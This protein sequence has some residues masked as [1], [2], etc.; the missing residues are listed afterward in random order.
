MPATEQTW[1]NQ[2]KLHVWFAVSSLILLIAT[3]WMFVKDHAREWKSYQRTAR[4]V[5]NQL[6]K[7]RIFQADADVNADVEREIAKQLQ[8][9]QQE[10]PDP[11]LLQKFQQNVQQETGRSQQVEGVDLDAGSLTRLQQAMDAIR[12]EANAANRTKLLNEMDQFVD[13]ARRLEN[14]KIRKRKFQ[15]ADVDEAKANY[16]IAV[17][18][19]LPTEEQQARLDVSLAKQKEL[20]ALT[21]DFQQAEA[22]RKA[23]QEIVTQIKAKTVGL[24]KRQAEMHADG[25][26]LRKTLEDKTSSYF[27][28]RLPFINQRFLELPIL[29]AFG[30]PLKIDNLWT[31]GLK[32]PYGS[33]GEVRRFDRCTTCHQSIDKT[34]AGM[35]SSGAFIGESTIV[36]RMTV[37][38]AAESS[39]STAAT[40]SSPSDATSSGT[41]AATE[42]G[43]EPL[44]T[45]DS[46]PVD[47][48][49]RR[50][51]ILLAKQGL[52]DANAATIQYVRADSP[53]ALAKVVSHKA[54]SPGDLLSGLRTGDVISAIGEDKITSPDQVRLH[55]GERAKPGQVLDITVK[56]GLPHPYASHPRLDLFVGSLSPHAKA[57]IGCTVCHEGQGTA[58]E[59]KWASHTPN[60]PDQSH[61]WSQEHGWFNNHHWLF[62]MY[63]KRFA[64]SGC[65]K[66]HHDV[67]ELRPSER[68]PEDPAPKVVEGHDLITEY[69]CFGCHEINGYK[70]DRRIG[71]DMRVEPNYFA[72]AAQITQDPNFNNVDQQIRDWA[73]RVSHHPEDDH[74]RHGLLQYLKDDAKSSE[75]VLTAD[76]HQI[77]SVLDDVD[78]PGTLRKVGPSLRHVGNKVGATFLF[79]WI[80]DPKHFRPTTRMPKFFGHWDHL[81]DAE[82]AVAQRYEP[83][84]I[85]GSVQ[86]LLGKSQ[87][88]DAPEDPSQAVW[89]SDAATRGARSF[90]LRGCL[91]CHTH[92]NFPGHDS[93]KG[94]ELTNIGNKFE[95]S[96]TPNARAW[97]YNWLKNPSN[98]HARTSMPDLQLDPIKDASGKMVDPAA[99]IA[100]FLLKSK[101]DWQPHPETVD[102]LKIDS[103]SRQALRDL[104]REYLHKA[105]YRLEV[106]EFLGSDTQPGKGIPADRARG[107]ERELVVA[108]GTQLSDQQMLRY[109][110]Q[111]TISK[112]GCYACHDIPGFE[113]AK[114]IGA[115]L[116]DWGQKDTS[117]IAFEHISEYV[118]HG[119]AHVAPGASDGSAS[120]HAENAANAAGVGQTAHDTF[121]EAFYQEKL[122]EH[123][124][125]GF[126]WQKLKEPRS[127]DYKM[128]AIKDYNDRLRM[129]L[130]PFTPEQREAVVTFVLGLVAQP[131]ADQF[132]Y[133]ADPRQEA[134][135][136]GQKVIEK[137]NC[138]GCHVLKAERWDLEFA[139]D[140][141][142]P[143]PVEPSYPFVNTAFTST[144]VAASSQ[145][146]PLRSTLSTTLHGMPDR[147]AATGL[148]VVWD[149][150]EE[151]LAPEDVESY[152]PEKLIHRFQLW[153][154]TLIDSNV[155]EVTPTAMSVPASAIK[156]RF[157]AWGGDLTLKL[158]PT[159]TRYEQEVN[160]AAK[161]TEAWAWLPPP[162]I[163]EGTKVQAE[164][165][166]DFLLDPHMIR[167]A[168]VMRMPKF[169]M[170]SSE[171]TAL[172]NFFAA[173]DQA[174]YPYA[175]QERTRAGHLL[176]TEQ[177]Y[178]ESLAKVPQGQRPDGASRLDHAMNI[179]VSNNYCIKCHRVGDYSPQASDRAKAPD[180]SVVYQRLRPDYVRRWIA[181]PR[182][183]LP[184][185]S[186]P[187]N[188]PYKEGDANLGGLDQKLFHGVSPQQVD[189]LVDLL[190][191]FNTYNQ[192]KNR[193]APMVKQAT[194]AATSPPAE[195]ASKVLPSNT[196]AANSVPA[197]GDSAS[198]GVGA[199]SDVG[200]FKEGR[201]LNDLGTVS[202]VGT[203]PSVA[204]VAR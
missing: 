60:N 90:E 110:G 2:K 152:S 32:M 161:G 167:P 69:G 12:Q 96:D 71:P 204:E 188:I 95:L 5:D 140:T 148:P 93:N 24:Q 180:L 105:F 174:E 160:P 10:S 175:Y 123:D 57:K 8:D 145:R 124:R 154:A 99:D 78:H 19:N 112:Y 79:D 172:V 113:D 14:Q 137:F 22:H 142:Q 36:V 192:G 122:H 3:L 179:V 58:T 51:G 104:T 88:V 194:P 107:A 11:A 198:S 101:Q 183:I 35:P 66:C 15:S 74:A 44:A 23:L 177:N 81:D 176:Q 75:P 64:E 178:Q 202:E 187:V 196:S 185:T 54:E 164:W 42:A 129:P 20:D 27:R 50:F 157:P 97:L 181:E 132:V 200:A 116:A 46:L 67:V 100:A 126:I 133:H 89:D 16:G 62:P 80:R 39:E 85:L 37:P 189:G 45:T 127:Y 25:K 169:N 118:H 41:H 135:L 166:H 138:T 103:Q 38:N 153:Q 84:E 173:R 29:D 30:S 144:Q 149:E 141:L 77:A 76:S 120:A 191:N 136:A 155:A 170:S 7:W 168:T 4:L 151:E 28:F 197:E 186:M 162:L 128:A 43:M 193:I 73:E 165:L 98:Y 48:M 63:P 49:E 115:A 55:L 86:Y 150:E 125:T 119:H 171:A 1:R 121:D 56:R 195:N 158:L 18:D 156:R 40:E 130:F 31:D 83:I 87:A 117:R 146:D 203:P 143:P 111:K 70:G 109:I 92:G 34:L 65:L 21:L 163:G 17:R 190:M 114:P 102:G 159:V 72:A 6:T 131:P 53:A 106:D 9:A 182:R 139:A 47:I 68:F 26:R 33:F 61:Q 201:A 134:L 91:A 59:F 52:I 13:S 94:P 147:N 108:S 199:S 184:Y 82:R